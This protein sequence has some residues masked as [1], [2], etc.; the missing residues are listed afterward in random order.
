MIDLDI[1]GNESERVYKEAKIYLDSP[2][3]YTGSKYRLIEI[4]NSNYPKD[5]KV[6]YD[7]F[8]GGGSVFANSPFEIIIANDIITP[9]VQFYK[10][11]QNRNWDD[12]IADV[13]SKNLD[14]SDKD[15]YLSLRERFN[16]TF[17]PVD[18]FIL[19]C[20][21]QNNMMRFNKKFQF[22]QTWGNRHFNKRT[23]EKL[24][25]YHGR[26]FGNKNITFINHNF[27]DI[28]IEDN[29]FVYL[30]PPYLITSAGYNTYWLKDHEAK[31]YDFVDSLNARNIKFMLSNVSKHKGRINPHMDRMQKYNIKEIVF[32]YDKVSRAGNS[33]ST[34]IL[35][36]NY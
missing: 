34:E 24:R 31:L 12:L 32:D 22:N 10:E 11:I 19:C 35:V 21:C 28:Q 1:F 2:L 7:V 29:S 13:K 23:E 25:G 26:I 9:L 5:I 6:M 15:G 16:K 36:M 14:P 30:D 8:C 20:T 3:N 27:Y 4:L 18:F 33:D 17:N